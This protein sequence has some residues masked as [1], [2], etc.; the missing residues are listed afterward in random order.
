MNCS[1]AGTANMFVTLLVGD[2]LEHRRRV[3]FAHQDR[4]AAD[5]QP[6]RG[7]AAA[8][9]VEQRHRDEVHLCSSKPQSGAAVGSSENRLALVSITPLGRPVVPDV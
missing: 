9:D 2:H 1:T 8:A 6:D 3:D 7:V 5:E 4:V